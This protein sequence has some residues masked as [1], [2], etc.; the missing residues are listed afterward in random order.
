M[1]SEL[2]VNT[3]KDASGNN[4]VATSTISNG[5]SK[6]YVN[7]DAQNQATDDSL[8]QSSLTD[9]ATGEFYSTFTS[10]MSSATAKAHYVS[11][12]NSQDDGANDISGAIRAGVHMNIGMY[13]N[14]RALSASEVSF[15]S[16]YGAYNGGN[17]AATD[18][19]MTCCMTLG[20]LA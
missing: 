12:L 18:L 13:D 4:S 14:H 16:A 9:V 15:S 3:L 19:S 17:G 20:D 5:V 11:A 1:A 7:Y 10:A 2:R 8:N 6:H